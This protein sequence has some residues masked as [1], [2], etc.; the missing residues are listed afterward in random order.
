[1]HY[2]DAECTKGFHW[3]LTFLFSFLE[4]PAANVPAKDGKMDK[5]DSYS[6]SDSETS[7]GTDGFS[8]SDSD[9]MSEDDDSSDEVDTSIGTD[10]SEDE[11]TPVVC[12]RPL[13]FFFCCAY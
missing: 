13:P 5:Q 12:T 8:D 7:S 4:K 6:E 9:D 10:D 2:L 3:V 11:E 1:V